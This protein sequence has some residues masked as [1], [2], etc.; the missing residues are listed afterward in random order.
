M[1]I[2]Y[3]TDGTCFLVS[4]DLPATNDAAGFGALTFTQADASDYGNLTTTRPLIPAHRKCVGVTTQV[5]GSITW[6][7]F[8]VTVYFNR[9]DATYTKLADSAYDINGE[10]MSFGI[11]HEQ[12]AAGTEYFTGY[13]A[14]CDRDY[15]G[16]FIMV[17]F[18]VTI[19]TPLVYVE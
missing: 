5:P 4:E 14:D 18:S 8:T 12:G 7:P 13:V 17:T 15:S 2:Q 11:A 10:K 19:D 1:P 9:D 6:S 3:K 16:D